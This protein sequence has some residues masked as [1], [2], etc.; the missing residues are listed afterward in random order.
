MHEPDVAVLADAAAAE[1]L[2]ER[3]RVA[4]RSVEVLAGV[5]DWSARRPCQKSLM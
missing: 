5:R 4:G 3:L 2:R 1:R